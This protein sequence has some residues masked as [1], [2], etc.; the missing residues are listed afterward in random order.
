[1]P[2]HCSLIVS[3]GAIHPFRKIVSSSASFRLRSSHNAREHSIRS[4]RGPICPA[5]GPVGLG[6]WGARTRQNRR[7]RTPSQ[8][9]A[10]S[11]FPL[12]LARTFQRIQQAELAEKIGRQAAPYVGLLETGRKQPSQMLASAIADTLGSSRSA[13]SIEETP[14]EFRATDWSFRRYQSATAATLTRVR[15]QGTLFL[16]RVGYLDVVLSLPKDTMPTIPRPTSREEIE[17]G[18]DHRRMQLGLG[19]D[20]PVNHVIRAFERAGVVVAAVNGTSGKIDAVSRAAGQRGVILVSD[21]KGSA[22]RRRY[23]VG[24]EGGHLVMHVGVE[25]GTPETEGEANVVFAS[26]FLL[27][28]RGFTRESFRDRPGDSGNGPTGRICLT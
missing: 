16:L 18:S 25:T 21:D 1:M 9:P 26:A 20:V 22:S 11:S 7:T 12:H 13:S 5:S 3:S 8:T 24:H 4:A 10:Y 15:A 27:W 6:R 14:D 19:L 17:R 28:R 2:R 23:D